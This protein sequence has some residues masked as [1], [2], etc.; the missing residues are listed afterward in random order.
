MLDEQVK[1]YKQ[2][3]NK[4][5]KCQPARRYIIIKQVIDQEKIGDSMQEY[6]KGSQKQLVH[7]AV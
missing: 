5:D 7:A 1:Q 6:S 3:D 4:H 2:Q